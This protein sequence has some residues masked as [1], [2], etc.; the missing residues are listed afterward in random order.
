MLGLAVAIQNREIT[1]P[2]GVIVEELEA[3]EYQVKDG[4]RVLY[5][6]PNGVHDDCVDALA[7]AVALWQN[8]N[9]YSGDAVPILLGKASQWRIG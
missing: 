4:G 7:M 1:F 9:K 8:R 2:D 3:F 6:A 5:A